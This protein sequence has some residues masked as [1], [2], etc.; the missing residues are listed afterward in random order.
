MNLKKLEKYN[1]NLILKLQTQR[2]FSSLLTLGTEGS[3]LF[4]RSIYESQ[5]MNIEI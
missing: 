2:K 3:S 4:I 5:Y 1:L